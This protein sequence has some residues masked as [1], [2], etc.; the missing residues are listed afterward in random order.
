MAKTHDII[1]AKEHL[2]MNEKI[3][4]VQ[5]NSAEETNA[6]QTK[7]PTTDAKFKEVVCPKVPTSY[8]KRA[9]KQ[10]A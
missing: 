5:N 8:F 10:K 4:S 7:T 3:K 2:Y 1:Q 6:E 9:K